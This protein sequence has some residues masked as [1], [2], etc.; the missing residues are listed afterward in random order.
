MIN[1]QHPVRFVRPRQR[2]LPGR[3]RGLASRLLISCL[4][5][6]GPQRCS[7]LKQHYLIILALD[8]PFKGGKRAHPS[9]LQDGLIPGTR[10]TGCELP[11][12]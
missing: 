8:R 6:R 9:A 4:L 12:L 10:S 7:R 11:D 1:T 5:S 2:R 3:F